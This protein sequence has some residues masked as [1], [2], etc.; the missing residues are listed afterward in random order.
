MTERKKTKNT[1][2]KAVPEAPA[3]TPVAEVNEKV[4]KALKALDDFAGYDQEKID[5]IVAK[6]SVAALDRH[7]ELAKMAIEET[8]RGVFEDKATKNLFA[9]EYVVNHMRNQKTVGIIDEDPVK[10]LKYVA[11]PVGVIA[12]ITPVTNPTSTAI[13]KSL[14][15]LKTRNPIIFAFHP[16]AQKCSAA[17]AKVMYDAAVAAGAPENCIQWI[18]VPSMDATSALMNHPGV[19]TILATGGNAM[20]KAAYSCGKPA[21][22]VG[23]GNVPAYIETTADIAEAVSDV[24]LSKA[25]DHGMVCASEQAVIVDKEIYEDVKNEFLHYNVHY[26]NEEEKKKLERFMFNAEAYGEGCKEARLNG[27]V[28]GK[29]AYWIAQQAGFEVDPDTSII[30]AECKEVGENEPLTREKLSP[31]LA[32]LKAESVEDGLDKAEA[33]VMFNGTGHSAA[34]HTANE[35]LVREYGRRIKACRIIWN[36]PSTF[37][38]IGNIYNSFIPSM[39][40]GCGS[41]GHNSVSDNISTVNLL[42]IKKI[43]ERRN[44]MQWFKIPSKI[45]IEKNSIEYLH[46]MREMNKVFIVTDQSMVK[47]GYVDKVTDQLARRTNKVTYELFCD[48]EPDPSIQTVRKGLEL[49]RSFE[50]DTIIALGGGSAID[51]AKGM[52]LYYEHPEVN[53][54]DLK[55]KFMDI[56]KRAFQYPELGKKANLVC[57]PTTSG[58]G[59]EVTPFAVITDRETSI[60]YPL[61]DYSLTPTVA[62]ID[63]ALTMTLPPAITANTGMDVL[64]HAV[65]AYVSVLASD[66]TDAL[67]LK[68]VQ[69][70]FEY[71]PRAVHNGANDPEARE[72]MHNASAMAG[73]AF[74]NAFLGM[75]HSMAHKVGAEFHVPHGLANAILL[76]YTI[77]YNG[78][79]PE[80]PGIWPKY[81]HYKADLRYCELAQAIGL[82]VENLQ[83]G[84]EAFAKAVETLGRDSGIDM[85]FCSLPYLDEEKWMAAAEKLSYLAYE[86]QC[87]P[88][89]PRVPMVRDMEEILRKAW[90]GEVIRYKQH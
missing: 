8:G 82:K 24:A 19:S 52:W 55:Q 42:N 5:Y 66:F 83:Q 77:R 41:Y 29:S 6:C 30:I 38:G 62:I 75:N 81:K 47:L 36:S 58:T 35:D 15:C 54:D 63:P 4:A 37:G 1:V 64:T 11:E 43:G 7:G 13:F 51:A 17:A 79:K 74:A 21:L 20:V 32:M 23:A 89:N 46:D 9:C 22:G 44:N 27:A 85:K 33:M 76:P 28:A 84:V 69:M 72:K 88:A 56:R 53:F 31:V 14:I 80:K 87:S 65:E 10:G 90:S 68:A 70:V 57:I 26:V 34:I 48:V 67:A 12:G 2:T 78:T 71:L 25:F 45:Y 49:M 60:K 86:D 40:L 18:E 73:M 61:T 39:T 59:S 50:P 3:P 16:N